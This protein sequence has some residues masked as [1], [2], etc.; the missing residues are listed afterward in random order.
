M[1]S[2]VLGVEDVSAYITFEEKVKLDNTSF[3][4]GIIPTTHV[5]IEQKSIGKDLR[6]SIKQSDGTYLTPFQ[7]AK[8]YSAELPYSQRPRWIVTCNFQ[9]FHIYD[10][11]RPTGEPESLLLE[12]LGTEYYRLN[13][14]VN[15]EDSNITKEKEISLQA[16]EIVGVLYDALLKQYKNPESPETLKSLNALCVRLVFCLY[17]EDAGIFGKRN[18]FH[19]YLNAHRTEDRRALINLFRI[20]DKDLDERG[21]YLDD[22]LAAFPY[23]NGGLFADENIVK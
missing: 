17:A 3:I 13:F 15:T 19:D 9:E 16:G 21:P 23:V 11:E 4:D 6:K 22:D 14:L 1:L 12:N 2:D 7:Q 5:L 10:M 8:R 20:L 18:M